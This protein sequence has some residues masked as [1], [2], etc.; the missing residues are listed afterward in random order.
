MIFLWRAILKLWWCGQFAGWHWVLHAPACPLERIFWG[1]YG[2]LGNMVSKPK[3]S[4]WRRPPSTCRCPL[5]KIQRIERRAQGSR[6][7]HS[8]VIWLKFFFWN[9]STCFFVPVKGFLLD[10]RQPSHPVS[11]LGEKYGIVDT[12]KRY[13]DQEHSQRGRAKEREE[14]RFSCLPPQLNSWSA[15]PVESHDD[16]ASEMRLFPQQWSPLECLPP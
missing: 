7:S 4:S 15:L 6:K 14:E 1:E 10:A 12:V 3:D 8:A 13:L 11:P 2:D 9:H 5:G 16:T